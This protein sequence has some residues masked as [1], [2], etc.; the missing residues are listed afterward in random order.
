MKQFAY[1]FVCT[2]MLASCELI[3]IGTKRQAVQFIDV[4]QNSALG[5]V[6]LF[7]TELDSNNVPAAVQILA[8]PDGSKYLAI[9]Q[10]EMYSEISRFKRIMSHREITSVITDTVSANTYKMNVELDYRRNFTF[11]AFKI[12]ND[13]FIVGLQ[14]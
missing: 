4:S 14:D 13:W 3:V 11:T 1:I 6:Y 10:Y 12:S 9:Q 8:K 2:M 5:A 7:K